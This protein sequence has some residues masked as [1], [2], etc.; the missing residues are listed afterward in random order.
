MLLYDG[1]TLKTSV[2][3]TYKKQT[4]YDTW[5]RGDGL[6]EAEPVNKWISFKDG[7]VRVRKG[8]WT[9]IVEEGWSARGQEKKFYVPAW[10]FCE[11]LGCE[12]KF[13]RA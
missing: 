12:I 4:T 2:M 1:K 3:L 8:D 10:H 13:S 7:F 9:T 11:V 6:Y 5:I